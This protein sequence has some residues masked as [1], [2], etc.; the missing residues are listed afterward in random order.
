MTKTPE[1]GDILASSWGYDQTN[2]NYYQVVGVTPSGKSV[3]IREI[4]QSIVRSEAGGLD[5]VVPVKDSFLDKSHLRRF[6]DNEPVTKRV[7]DDRDG[8]AVKVRSFAWAYQADTHEPR[9]QT[10]FG[11]GH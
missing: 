7:Q 10:A 5:Y 11:F 3:R 1:V 8:Y 9:Y 2:I 6:V 4:A